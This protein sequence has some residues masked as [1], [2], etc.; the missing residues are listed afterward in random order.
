MDEFLNDDD[1]KDIITHN[2][3]VMLQNVIDIGT[4]LIADAGWAEPDYLAE[5]P[6]ILRQ[7][8]VIPEGLTG[9]LKAMIGLRNL[10]AHEYGVLDYRIIYRIVSEDLGDIQ[11][12]L[13]AIIEYCRL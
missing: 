1:L 11:C 12:F 9:P 3:F 5:I 4:H 10:I 8:K 2:L 13:K 7:E 6:E